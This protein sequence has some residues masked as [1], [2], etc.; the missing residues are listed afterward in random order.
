MYMLDPRF[1]NALEEYQR[2]RYYPADHPDPLGTFAEFVNIGMVNALIEEHRKG[3]ERNL[4]FV[5]HYI[6]KVL[7]QLLDA[8]IFSDFVG[9]MQQKVMQ[10]SLVPSST[11][12]GRWTTLEVS[13][14]GER[15]K[16]GAGNTPRR[17]MSGP[18]QCWIGREKPM[19][20]STCR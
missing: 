3:G 13:S 12:Q 17:C 5:S 7:H 19:V 20:P 9:A 6:L 10:F 14:C 8:E 16:S 15:C 4:L 2:K 11:M 18:G 1:R